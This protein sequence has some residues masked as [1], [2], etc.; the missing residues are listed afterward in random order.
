MYEVYRHA[1]SADGDDDDANG[2]SLWAPP[3][4][5]SGRPGGV[6]NSVR[7]RIPADRSTGL[8]YTG[9]DLYLN[10][11]VSG[12]EWPTGIYAVGYDWGSKNSS[13][14]PT[15]LLIMCC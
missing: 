7:F 11:C 3:L 9:Y 10:G 12:Q 1:V 5:Y 13:L 8:R 2:P 4:L 6:S 15:G 14:E